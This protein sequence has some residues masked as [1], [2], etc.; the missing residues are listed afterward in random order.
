MRLS[1]FAM[2]DKGFSRWPC[3][4]S[5]EIAAVSRVLRSG[6]V[7]YWTG[8]EGHAFEQEFAAY[9]GARYGV[10]V[11]NGTVALELALYALGIGPGDEVVVTARTFLASV[12]CIVNAG[13]RPVFADVDRTSGNITAETVR[14]VLTHRTRAIMAV[15]LSGW[16]CDMDGLMHIAESHGLYVIED[17]AQA[18]G[19]SWDGRMV[20]S[21][22]HAA[23]FSFCTDKIMSTGGEGG[24]L[25]FQDEAARRRAWS[26]KDHGKDWDAVYNKKHP[27][28]FRWLHSSFGT[29]WRLTEMQAA[30]GR[31]QLAKLPGWIRKRRENAACLMEGLSEIPGI[32]VPVP[33]EKANPA[34]YK[35]YVYIEPGTLRSSWSRD[36]VMQT[37]SEKGIPCMQGI[38]PEVYLEKAFDGSGFRPS[39]RLPVAREMGETSLMLLVHPTLGAKEMAEMVQI[40]AEVMGQA[41]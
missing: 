8:E 37:I 40:F 34:W 2:A 23:A 4:A 41:V 15:H 3:Y 32:R 28:G 12:S 21:F 31:T 16:P 26:F 7:N 20:G 11:A 14:A 29:N 13:A 27:P 6:R 33:G 5:D 25:L 10:A 39:E 35:F 19:A 38:C 9:H 18:H 36:R 17:C 22:G 1:W 24:M 30:I